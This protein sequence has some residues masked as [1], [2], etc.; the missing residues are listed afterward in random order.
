MIT[1]D[2]LEKNYMYLSKNLSNM[3]AEVEVSVSGGALDV[4]IKTIDEQYQRYMKKLEELSA[5][6]AKDSYA[7]AFHIMCGI[8]YPADEDLD[9][10]RRK[11][12]QFLARHLCHL[13]NRLFEDGPEVFLSIVTGQ[14]AL[15]ECAYRMSRIEY[16]EDGWK[17]NDGTVLTDGFWMTQSGKKYS[18]MT[19]NIVSTIVA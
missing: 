14:A 15:N 1:Y 19:A 2:E 5:M 4:K 17:T 12:K 3:H 8:R 6:V 16:T 9:S 13:F 18:D 11:G 7:I 10:E